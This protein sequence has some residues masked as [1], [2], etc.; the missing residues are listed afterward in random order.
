MTSHQGTFEETSPRFEEVPINPGRI[1]RAIARI[2]YTPESAICDIV[3]NSVAANA[4][5]VAIKLEREPDMSEARRNSAA[6]YIIA[7]DGD[8][9]DQGRLIEAL[10]LGAEGQY[11]S[12]SLGK[13][14]LGLKSA[15]LS[16][17][18]RI[19]VVSA[20]QGGAWSK[21]V[22]DLPHV[23][24]VGKLECLV[25]EPDSADLERVNQL[26]P[27]AAHGTVVTIEK[28]HKRNHPSIRKTRGALERNLGVT[29]FY[30]LHPNGGDLEILL[31]GDPVKPFD[32]L[33]VDEANAAGNLDD[34]AWDGLDVRW[35]E[36]ASP[37]ILDAE[38]GVEA[39][40]EATQ[41][42]YPPAFDNSAEI[43]K[44]YMVGGN[45]YGFY[46]YRNKRLIRRAERFNGIIPTDQDYFAFRGRILIDDSAD[47]AFNIDVKKSEI[48]LSEEA[49]SALSEA[50]YEA[51]RLSKSGWRNAAAILR[52]KA[53][54]DPNSKAA[55]ALSEV[56]FPEFLPTD[57]DDAISE[58]ERTK[59]TEK[60]S[61]RHPLKDKER[62]QVRKE[63]A[64]VTFVDQLDDNA[65]WERARDA[66]LGTVVRINRSHRFM[67]M[68][69]ERFGDDADVVLLLQ[70]LFLSLASAESGTVRNKQDL[71][72]EIIEEVF[73]TYRN[74][75]SAAVYK[76]TADALEK[77]F[78]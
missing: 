51:R 5:R 49:E 21:A 42:V 75:A 28:I 25:M 44:R 20:R 11:D 68:F 65:L 27:G 29:Y 39:T 33:F 41:L 43:R 50:I 22:L 31:D 76:V 10:A 30:F 23:E 9:M 40:I 57:P 35:L 34:S 4:R 3:D 6:R 77:R 60:E 72:D 71:D 15:G 14:G 38:N 64:R 78:A 45:N 53:N 59:R 37:V 32:P 58:N 55:E 70:A 61:A 46:I 17:G 1:L 67:R 26:I 19:E 73:V 2:G 7:D 8:G 13:Y 74:Q 62:E 12:G 56:E 47:D 54:E 18:D 69:D 66:T 16:Q 48:L 52:K 24:R 36:R 63:G